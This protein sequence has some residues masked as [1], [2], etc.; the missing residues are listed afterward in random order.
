VRT[1]REIYCTTENCPE[2]EFETRLFWRSLP[3]WLRPIALGVWWGGRHY[4]QPDIELLAAIGRAGTER[5]LESEIAEFRR[6]GRNA[7]F[8]RR[9]LRLRIST[10]RLRRALAAARARRVVVPLP[11]ER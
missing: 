2:S 11:L 4:F 6:D 3:P 7:T 5:E 10:R 1:I 9:R 8:W